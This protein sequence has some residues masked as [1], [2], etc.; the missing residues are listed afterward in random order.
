MHLGNREFD[1]K[2]RSTLFV[3]EGDDI[4]VV[5]F[6]NAIADGQP[7][8]AAFA[9]LL[10]GIERIEYPFAILQPRTRV[11]EFDAGPAVLQ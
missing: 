6:H 4:S 7:E 3:V 8:S 10:R 5:P 1:L 9:Y 2:Y 11:T